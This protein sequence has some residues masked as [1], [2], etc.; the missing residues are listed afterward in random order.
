MHLV[1]CS[2]QPRS[3]RPDAIFCALCLTGGAPWS[4]SRAA[5]SYAEPEGGH[6]D[7]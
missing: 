4:P 1:E 5:R 6:R 7:D 2:F 3:D